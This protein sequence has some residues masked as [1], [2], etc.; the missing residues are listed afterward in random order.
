MEGHSAGKIPGACALPAVKLFIKTSVSLGP[1]TQLC[2][3][4]CALN[5]KQAAHKQGHKGAVPLVQLSRQ[6][7][8]DLG[9]AQPRCLQ[10]RLVAVS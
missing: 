10:A 1:Q 8:A 7:P 3:P 6:S 5:M 2:K 9:W 4:V